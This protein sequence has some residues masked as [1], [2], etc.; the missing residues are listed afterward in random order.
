MRKK[1]QAKQAQSQQGEVAKEGRKE[2]QEANSQ[3]PSR[4]P[5]NYN[6]LA[7][8]YARY[9]PDATVEGARKSA[10]RRYGEPGENKK[11]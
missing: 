5:L 11:T 6:M 7:S 10:S 8:K 1:T 9:Y 4:G 2:Q 3:R